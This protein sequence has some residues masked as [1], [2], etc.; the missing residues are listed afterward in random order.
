M[1]GYRSVKLDNEYVPSS[2]VTVIVIADLRPVQWLP[3]PVRIRDIYHHSLYTTQ[4]HRTRVA[5]YV[6]LTIGY[7]LVG[8][9]ASMA[10]TRA[11]GYK[12]DSPL[13]GATRH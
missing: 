1:V 9:F 6:S 2:I 3:G 11:T 7:C 4:W 12:A 8:S 10:E 5:I 13:P